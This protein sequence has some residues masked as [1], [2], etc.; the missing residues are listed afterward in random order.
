MCLIP[1]VIIRER[2]EVSSRNVILIIL[3]FWVGYLR[4]SVYIA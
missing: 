3:F 1:Y 2:K 4:L